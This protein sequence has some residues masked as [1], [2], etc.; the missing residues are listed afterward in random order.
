MSNDLKMSAAWEWGEW[1]EGRVRAWFTARG[2][3]VVPTSCI[4]IGGAPRLIGHLRS[5]VLPDLQ[6]ARAGVCR[7]VE[8]KFK[9][10][11]VLYEKTKR[12]RHGIDQR[13]FEDYLAVERETG[14]RGSLALYQLQRGPSGPADPMLLWAP[15]AELAKHTQPY[16]PNGM[17][18]WDADVM[19]RWHLS[20][21]PEPPA[22]FRSLLNVVHPW[23]KPAA[24]GKSAPQMPDSVQRPLDFGEPA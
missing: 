7:W 6:V 4:E 15:L 23:E 5:H 17:V 18:Y 22:R 24:D 11:P 13:L 12:W 8:V 1:G 9:T 2:Y 20:S 14:I 10:R 21:E 3:F 16:E 19:S